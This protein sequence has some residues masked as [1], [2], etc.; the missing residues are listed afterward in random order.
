MGDVKANLLGALWRIE[1]AH[2]K[3]RDAFAAA[4]DPSAL[5]LLLSASKE[6]VRLIQDAVAAQNK[7]NSND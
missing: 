3:I 7:A 5:I 2:E 1:T 6:L 4:E